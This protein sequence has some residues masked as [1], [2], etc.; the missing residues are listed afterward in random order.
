[1]DAPKITFEDGAAYERMMGTWSRIAGELFI[2]W[3]QP[4][5][6]LHWVDV[7]CGNGAF[8]ELLIDRC[9]ASKVE[10]VDPSEAQISFARSRRPGS[11]IANFQRGDALSL[12]FQND[13]FDAAAMALVIFFLPDPAKGVAE[14]SRVVKPGGIV[15]AY[16]WDVVGGG[17]PGA[18]VSQE[19]REMGLPPAVIPSADASRLDVMVELWDRAGLRD[20][21][22][23]PFSVRRTFDNFDNYWE[24]N[25]LAP[26]AGPVI[27]KM[28]PEQVAELKQR[29]RSLLTANASGQIVYEA[30]ANA[31]KGVVA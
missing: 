11:N 31:V 18:P 25:L 15:S 19:L 7:G 22:T 13:S 8:T 4:P 17:L 12:P 5:P 6:K 23:K 24:I 2:E 21:E 20:V 26:A 27:E 9:A 28:K 29:V 16:A 3:L 1:M 10:G 14:M 30:R